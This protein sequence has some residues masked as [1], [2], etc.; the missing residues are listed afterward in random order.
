MG[1]VS[2]G[3]SVV[4][5]FSL[6]AGLGAAVYAIRECSAVRNDKDKL[7]DTASQIFSIN[8][9]TTV[10][11]YILLALTLAFYDKLENYRLLIAVQSLSILATAFGAD[12]INSAMEDFK[13][14]TIRS[15][16]FQLLS[17]VLM[18]AFVHRPEDYLIHAVIALVSTAGANIA[19]IWYRRKY[20]R[21]RFTLGIEW[22]RHFA[23]ISVLFV[24]ILAQTI[25]S[26]V[27]STMLGLMHGDREVGIYSAANKMSNIIAQLVASV[28]WVVMPRMAYYFAEEDYGQINELLR[29]ILGFHALLGIPCAVGTFML[30][31]E[32]VLIVSG[33]G[34][35]EASEVLKV[36][37][38][39]MVFTLF[40]G[41]F[42][43]NAILLPSKKENIFMAVCCVAA[44]VN[45]LTNYI[46]IPK[47]GAI[48][49]AGTT[50]LCALVIFFSLLVTMDKRIK[51]RN[52]LRLFVSPVV[53]SIGIAAVCAL[54]KPIQSV[55]V[56]SF[57]GIALSAGVYFAVNY[58]G[59][60]ELLREFVDGL[61]AK[62]KNVRFQ[63]ACRRS[64]G[65][66]GKWR[67]GTK[68]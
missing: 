34:F 68:W 20:C 41:S 66:L 33:S 46:F 44:V 32:I 50:A 43:G 56:R 64:R 29:K 3:A 1:K 23:P 28:L 40:G 65:L 5:Y 15:V 55:W 8:I 2:F 60:N 16:G 22:R 13:Y 62:R 18:F 30:S 45:V 24:M 27:D 25:F 51:I 17:L 19:N 48:A 37:M 49:A 14:I 9:I 54:S 57:V 42:L 21:I 11:A 53:G 58:V 7:S 36:L 26:S 59:R 31:D 4:S 61:A 12:W 39:G 63:G 10:I 67:N 47:Y 38:V 52:I 6:I 35:A